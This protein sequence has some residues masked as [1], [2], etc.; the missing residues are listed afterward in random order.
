MG[1]NPRKVLAQN[2][3][4]VN[5]G[6]VHILD[7][8]DS[9]KTKW[10]TI[11]LAFAGASNSEYQ[12]EMERLF[13]RAKHSAKTTEQKR[14][15]VMIPAF[16]NVIFKGWA[17]F[18]DEVDGKEVPLPSNKTNA[19]KLFID[20]KLFFEMLVG[21]ATDEDEYDDSVTNEQLTETVADAK[22]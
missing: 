1:Y 7:R 15:Q 19:E 2:A 9:N 6:R 14:R 20:D 18:V 3:K 11:T 21:L 5:E 13:K 16:V 22:K 10:P 12:R 17:N 8:S 4:L